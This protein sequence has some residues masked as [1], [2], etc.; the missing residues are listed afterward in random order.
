MEGNWKW[1][2]EALTSAC[3]K[4]LGSRKHH[5]NE[6]I[7]MENLRMIQERKK[8]KKTAAEDNCRTRTEKVETQ[9]EYME[10]KKQVERSIR[11]DKQKYVENLA[12]TAGN[13]AAEGNMKQ[14]YDTRKLARKYNKPERPVKDKEGE[15][16]TEIQEQGKRCV[17]H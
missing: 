1:V 13:A 4:I 14:P 17:K 6:W 10:A 2:R 7:S 5:R 9:A 16:I 12:I 3:R 11:A 8:K 15:P